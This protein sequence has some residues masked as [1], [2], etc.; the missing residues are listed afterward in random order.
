VQGDSATYSAIFWAR[1]S[2]DSQPTAKVISAPLANY[3][4]LDL[5]ADMHDL[6]SWAT[7]RGAK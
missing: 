6:V 2:A 5:G 1:E 7:E 4:A 3:I